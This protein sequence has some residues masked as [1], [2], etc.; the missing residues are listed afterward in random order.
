M[1]LFAIIF[2]FFSIFMLPSSGQIPLLTDNRVSSGIR[3]IFGCSLTPRVQTWK[4]FALNPNLLE[5]WVLETMDDLA[6]KAPYGKGRVQIDLAF[7]G[8]FL[9]KE[10]VVGLFERAK[11]HGIRTITSHFVINALLRSYFLPPKSPS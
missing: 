9:P 4:P 3:S 10:I 6:D 2:L 11:S 7:D 5:D 1:R 8:Y